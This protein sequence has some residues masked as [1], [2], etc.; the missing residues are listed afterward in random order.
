MDF[1]TLD[2]KSAKIKIE[3]ELETKKNQKNTKIQKSKKQKQ[4]QKMENILET[5]EFTAANPA[6][7]INIV[8]ELH[9][10][11]VLQ[12][13]PKSPEK[14]IVVGRSPP[15]I[16]RKRKRRTRFKPIP[17]DSDRDT[18]IEAD[19]TDT[20]YTSEEENTPP[21]YQRKS[22]ERVRLI[23]VEGVSGCKRK[24]SYDQE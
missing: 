2:Q 12:E 17:A 8:Q 18:D 20:D 11:E 10:I 6:T 22:I 19:H 5:Y 15:C 14:T 4:K 13:T 7:G 21:N 23:R 24:L 9:E 1:A 3:K 16:I